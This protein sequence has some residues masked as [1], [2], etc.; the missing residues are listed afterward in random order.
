MTLI[1][2][3]RIAISIYKYAGY[4]EKGTTWFNRFLFFLLFFLF[5]SSLKNLISSFLR[6][7][8]M[9]NHNI[10]DTQ[11]ASN[12]SKIYLLLC[13]KLYKTGASKVCWK[14]YL[15]WNENYSQ[16]ICPVETYGNSVSCPRFQL[17]FDCSYVLEGDNKAFCVKGYSAIRP[18]LQFAVLPIY[19]SII[20]L[21]R[22]TLLN[23]RYGISDLACFANLAVHW[24]ISRLL[25]W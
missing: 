21:N 7:E 17:S 8:G 1:L 18:F 19:R 14:S 12:L 23:S 9:A 24:R 20:P 6:M 3:H 15:H 5:F 16:S 11:R 25:K 10:T 13:R 4:I 22:V 2:S